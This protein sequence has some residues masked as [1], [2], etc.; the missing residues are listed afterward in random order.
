MRRFNVNQNHPNSRLFERRRSFI[1][2][3]RRSWDSLH[4]VPPC[5]CGRARCSAG[6]QGVEIRAGRRADNAVAFYASFN[7]G[8]RRDARI[9]A[10]KRLKVGSIP[11]LRPPPATPRTPKPERPQSAARKFFTL[12]LRSVGDLGDDKCVSRLPR[13]DATERTWLPTSFSRQRGGSCSLPCC[14]RHGA[15]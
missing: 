8:R 10:S 4:R 7:L 15:S 12:M 14:S 5:N 2:A 6:G 11:D 3:L 9:S 13:R 1:W